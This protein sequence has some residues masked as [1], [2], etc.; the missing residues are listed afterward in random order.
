MRGVVLLQNQPPRIEFSPTS[1]VNGRADHGIGVVLNPTPLTY[2]LTL[3]YLVC[4]PKNLYKTLSTRLL[5]LVQL[6]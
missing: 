6:Y 4:G 1:V 2:H 3:S 5:Q